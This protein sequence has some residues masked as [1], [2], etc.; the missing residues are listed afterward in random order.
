MNNVRRRFADCRYG[1][2]LIREVN[3]GKGTPLLCLHATA[4]SSQSFL[5]LMTAF[6]DQ[7]HVLAID[8]PGYGESDGPPGAVSIAAYAS[9]I[10]EV[11][12][13]GALDLFGYHTGVVLAVELAIQKPEAIQSLALMGVPYFEPLG[14]ETWKTRLA[15]PHHLTNDLGQFQERWQW[16]VTDRPAGMSLERAFANFVD[17]LRAWPNGY[18]AHQALFDYD[19]AS[20]FACVQQQV[21][22]LNPESHLAEASRIA[23]ALFPRA[24]CIELPRMSGAVLEAYA[25]ELV[26]LITE[27]GH[28]GPASAPGV[29]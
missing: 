10:A 13:D 27:R 25:Q 12:P 20:R 23:A 29:K 17:E 16:L 7:R 8:A 21:T 5:P 3:P 18:R 19:C 14:F 15:S 4:Y 24:T 2:L 11:L 9:A 1:Q 22:V 6:G 28:G 26:T